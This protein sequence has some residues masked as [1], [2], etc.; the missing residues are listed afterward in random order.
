MLPATSAFA[1]CDGLLRMAH[2]FL[3]ELPE[4]DLRHIRC[5]LESLLIRADQVLDEFEF[6]LSLN[7]DALAIECEYCAHRPVLSNHL[8]TAI[9]PPG[10]K[11]LARC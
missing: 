5:T 1:I 9:P 7:F 8:Q 10:P 11:T 4:T 3:M 2:C 6:D